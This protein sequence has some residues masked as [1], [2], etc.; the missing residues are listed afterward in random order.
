MNSEWSLDVLYKGTS[1]PALQADMDKLSAQ[2]AAYKELIA[3]LGSEDPK[4]TLRKVIDAKE[5]L[6][7]LSRRLGGYFS[8]RKSANSSDS[9]GSSYQTNIQ[10]LGDSTASETAPC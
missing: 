6:A 4:T 9:E 10:A 3:S 8:P 1:D 5:E 7:V 2:T